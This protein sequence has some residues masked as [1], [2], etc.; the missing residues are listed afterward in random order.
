MARGT[1]FAWARFFMLS[2]LHG[3]LFDGFCDPRRAL[4]GTAGAEQA[5]NTQKVQPTQHGDT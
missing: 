2:I 1:F 5:K 4:Q 3:M